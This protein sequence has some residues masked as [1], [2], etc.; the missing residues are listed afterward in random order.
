MKSVL[1][2]GH[3]Y[4]VED[5]EFQHIIH[6]EYNNLKIYPDVGILERYIG[7]IRDLAETTKPFIF[8]Y[9]GWKNGGF[10]PLN[11]A[12][13]NIETYIY[14]ILPDIS[15]TDVD[16]RVING[17]SINPTVIYI[18]SSQIDNTISKSISYII[19]EKKPIIIAN[20]N[21]EIP[22]QYS[23]KYIL[24]DS[25]KVL[26]VDDNNINKFTECFKYYIVD[27][28][29]LDYNNL[30]HL[31]IMVKN[32]GDDFEKILENNLPCID[33]WT[34]LDTGSTDNTIDIINR[35]LVGK[36][37][38]NLYQEP[39]INFR[40]SRN[41]CMDL[42]GT[43]C[44]FNLFLDDTYYVSGNL[45]NFLEIARGD[46]FSTSF[47]TLIRSDDMEYYSNRIIKSESGLRYIYTIHEVIDYNNNI[48]VVIPK[49]QCVVIDQQ[50]PYMGNRTKER[51]M[52]DLKLLFDMVEEEPENPRHLY[53]IA[54]TY[55]CIG[56]L[57]KV[58]EYFLKR[59]EH[60][61]EG[62][63]QEKVDTYFELAR[64]YNFELKKPWEECEKFYKKAYELEPSRP[65]P[66]YFIG[67]HYLLKNERYKAF[68][69]FKKAITLGYPIHTQYSL[70]PTL[71][72]HFLPKFLTPLCYEFGDYITGQL[73]A[74]IFLNNNDTSADQYRLMNDWYITYKY[75]NNCKEHISKDNIFLP[76]KKQ[77]ICFI[78]DGGFHPWSGKDILTKGVGGSETFIIEI[79]RHIQQ[80]GMF[81]V[82]VFCNCE[83]ETQ[84]EGV[85]YY[86]LSNL[87]RI[88]NSTNIHT[89]VISR[90]AEYILAC[91]ECPTIKN[92]CYIMHDIGPSI[93]IIP[94]H[95]KVR[96]ILCLTNWH[97]EFFLETFPSFKEKT[98]VFGYGI[99]PSVFEINPPIEK[100]PFHFIYSSFP[101]RGLLPLLMMWP[102]IQN[103]I[104]EA[105]L[106]IYS[107]VN[108]KWVN[109]VEPDMMIQ[110]RQL[111]RSYEGKFNINYH[112]WVDKKTL[113]EAW[114]RADIWLYPCIFKETYCLTAMEAAISKTIVITNGLAALNET[115]GD[116]S[117]IIPGDPMTDIWQNKVVEEIVKI[118]DS[119]KE[120]DALIKE[121]YEWAISNTWRK[122]AEIFQ[123]K[124][125][126]QYL[127]PNDVY[128][129]FQ[130]RQAKILYIG[131][132]KSTGV[133]KTLVNIMEYVPD[134]I[135]TF[136]DC[137]VHK[138]NSENISENTYYRDIVE[139]G[140]SDNIYILKGDTME[141]LMNCIQL[142]KRYSIIYIDNISSN[143][144]I[145][146]MELYN[147]MIISWKLLTTNGIL[148]VNNCKQED[149]I[150]KK[151]AGLN[152]FLNKY[153]K[154][155]S[156]ITTNNDTNICIQKN[157]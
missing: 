139:N 99:D 116:R 54:Q 105:S 94:L 24:K 49:D 100:V 112:G 144:D 40:E 53:Y 7:L 31:L 28:N 51:K 115:A 152:Y 48:N 42:A 56:D 126:L 46:Q 80:F 155:Y 1:L 76:Q 23:N 25:N 128:T 124:Y 22:C 47:S 96:D 91:V 138:D 137:H 101:N 41:R 50:S 142:G 143:D 27:G 8:Q 153:D 129:R 123:E 63:I 11:C 127:Q 93:N 72:Y 108:G 81:D 107:D 59:I 13:N 149:I 43:T 26:Y 106:H 2:N 82:F 9:I 146:N 119:R 95:S 88:I 79:A 85:Q 65:D 3:T 58:A 136:I 140:I 44:K 70:K 37:K 32:A 57:E 125:I 60:P 78:A 156:I 86:K 102:Q 90:Y 97:K 145:Y 120:V 64:L 134:A 69:Y 67:I 84:F 121:N 111:L 141:Q 150:E 6:N 36:R 103:A 15:E 5:Y 20:D 39:F 98:S 18:E 135:I 151:Y 132:S 21:Y 55:K 29:I 77:V 71:Y 118:R 147:N 122:R 131:G 133:G 114:N 34:I 14:P 45:R 16:K 68:E 130:G 19:T 4:Y 38:G 12:R 35:V 73:S 113:A 33:R 154:C 104:P 157:T 52:M 110:I 92:I 117:I 89:C 74:E 62:F 66:L 109:S 61:N 83:E 75:V 148:C 30:I 87:Y 17:L 10:I